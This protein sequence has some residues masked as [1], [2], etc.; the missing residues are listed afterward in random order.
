MF[1][2]FFLVA[3]LI[4]LERERIAEHFDWLMNL[5]ATTKT[6]RVVVTFY[7]WLVASLVAKKWAG[8]N[9]HVWTHV[10]ENGERVVELDFFYN[11]R[12]HKIRLVDNAI[13]CLV[14]KADG[15][16]EE[17]PEVL[18]HF[19]WKAENRFDPELFDAIFLNSPKAAA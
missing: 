13:Q 9:Q 1:S 2:E 12:M 6:I 19:R 8:W 7:Y 4:L 17:R 10:G 3:V 5:S 14:R 15:K 18:D 16:R 11:Y